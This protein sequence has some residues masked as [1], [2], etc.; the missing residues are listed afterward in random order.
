MD[1]GTITTPEQFRDDMILTFANAMKYN[2]P[3]NDV[4]KIAKSVNELF[5]Q[6]WEKWEDSIKQKWRLKSSEEKREVTFVLNP[7]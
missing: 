7:P 1:N 5:V 3:E 6:E 2:P 4:Y